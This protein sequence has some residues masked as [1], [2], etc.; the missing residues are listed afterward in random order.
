MHTFFYSIILSLF[1]SYQ[2][3]A[4]KKSAIV[5]IKLTSDLPLSPNLKEGKLVLWSDSLLVYSLDSILLFRKPYR[6]TYHNNNAIKDDVMIFSDDP[7][8]ID[9]TV[10]KY[11]D[12]LC[13][14]NAVEG[15]EYNQNRPNN[16]NKPNTKRAFNVDSF[17][18]E[19]A[20]KNMKFITNGD[21]LIKVEN[22]NHLRKEIYFDKLKRGGNYPDTTSLLFDAK[23]NKIDFSLSKE[24]D[25]L[26]KMKLVEVYFFYNAKPKTVDMPNGM[27]KRAFHFKIEEI[28]VNNEDKILALFERFKRDKNEGLK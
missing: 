3:I 7:A 6:V 17:L 2:P 20:Y 15:Y 9:S 19:N 16:R 11:V 12:Y 18:V 24:L 10:V 21:E 23:F 22:T 8:T 1:F 4:K 26:R 14:K 27:P 5:A 28:K 25:S 13:Y